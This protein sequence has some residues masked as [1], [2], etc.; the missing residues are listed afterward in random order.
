MTGFEAR[1]HIAT[2]FG[3]QYAMPRERSIPALPL[4]Y[5]LPPFVVHRAVL[6]AYDYGFD[7]ILTRSPPPP[8]CSLQTPPPRRVAV[9]RSMRLGV[10][11]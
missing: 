4:H 7:N 6:A 3:S 2:P 8:A 11:F 10:S 1:S 9:V 5:I